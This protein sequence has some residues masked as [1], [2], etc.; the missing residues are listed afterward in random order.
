[1]KP[2]SPGLATATVPA[3]GLFAQA[4]DRA[5]PAVTDHTLLVIAGVVLAVIAFSFWRAASRQGLKQTLETAA[6]FVLGIPLAWMHLAGSR[7][8]T[9]FP[10]GALI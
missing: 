1:V 8:L 10:S 7:K 2:V 9:G 4:G 5:V 3:G 6:R